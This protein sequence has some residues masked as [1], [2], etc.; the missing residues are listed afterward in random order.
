MNNRINYPKRNFF[1]FRFIKGGVAGLYLLCLICTKVDAGAQ[2]V[3][4]KFKHIT[5]EQ[6]LSSNR[7]LCILR[8]SRDF[9]WVGTDMGLNKFDG[10]D[11]T[12]YLHDSHKKGT[13][14]G[15]SI[16][17][18]TED[19]HRNL[20]FGTSEGL[21]L[22][23]RAADSFITFKNNPA[24]P[25]SISSNFIISIYLDKKQNFWILAGGNCL[26]L[27]VPSKRH[28]IRYQF[29]PFEDSYFFS[30]PSIVEDSKGNIW[31]TSFGDSLF[32][33]EQKSQKFISYDLALNSSQKTFNS[34]Y[35]D[36]QEKLWITSRGGGLHS[37]EP[38]TKK[39]EHFQIKADGT[40]TNKS[41]LHWII[42]ED[43]KHLLIA[44]DQGGINRF[45]LE[46]KRFEYIEYKEDD[47]QG[48][49]N[50]AIWTLYK[51]K[52]GILWVGTANGGINYHNPKE[53]NFNL[54]KKG[55][56]AANPNSNLIGGFL[57]D[58]KGKIW[59]ATDDNGINVFDPQ[60]KTFSFYQHN[61]ANPYSVSGNII[62]SIEEDRQGNIWV[63]TW[64]AGLNRFNRTTKTFDRFLPDKKQPSS[65]SGSRIWYLKRDY[66]GLIWSSVMDIGIDILDPKKGVV[67][68]YR[69][70]SDN[71]FG[72]GSDVIWLFV[73]DRQRNMWVCTWKGLYRYDSAHDG[74]IGYK[75]FPD[76]DIR[77]FLQDSK[78]N[79]WAGSA[80]KGIFKFSLDGKVLNQYDMNHGLP[81][82]QVNAM[83]E[84]NNG[85]IWITTNLGLSLYDPDKDKFHNYSIHDGLQGNQ[86]FMQSF[87]KTRAGDIYFGGF[88]GFNSFNPV[89]LKKNN[90]HTPVYIT[91]FQV[92][93]KRVIPGMPD[94][95]LQNQI[96]ETKEIKL[97]WKQSVFSF[98][99]TAINYT[100]SAK[101]QYAYK[102]DGF[103]KEWNYVGDKRT[104]T[105]TNLDP[106]EYVFRVKASNNNGVWNEKGT[107]I[108]IIITPP[109][110]ATWWFRIM[111]ALIII[112]GAVSFYR[113]RIN[114]VE[115]ARKDLE[116]QVLE[117]TREERAARN[118]A[119]EANKAKSIFLATMS[120][121]IRTPMNGVI[122]TASLLADTPLSEEQRRYT[123]IIRSSGESLLTVINDILDFSKIE[124]GKIDLEEVPFN[125]RSSMEEVLDLFATKAA[126][127]GIDLIYQ[128][129]SAIPQ[130]IVGDCVRLK[131]VMINLIGNAIKFT[132]KGEVFLD[133]K[134]LQKKEHDLQLSFHIHDTGIGIPKEKIERLFQAF[135]Q[136]DSSTTRKYGGTGLGLAISKRLVEL[137]GGNISVESELGK[138]T[139]F[140]I[141]VKV[142][143][144][145]NII[146]NTIMDDL[147]GL[148]GKKVLIVDDNETSRFVL[149]KQLEDW[150]FNVLAA[151]S[152]KQALKLL[153]TENTIDLVISDMQMPDMD[154][155]VL[156]KEIAKQSAVLPV[157][158]LSSIGG[159][160]DWETTRE[161]TYRLAKPV[162]QQQLCKAI[163][164]ALKDFVQTNAEPELQK[165]NAGFAEQY[166][167]EI[168][169][170]EDNPVNQ[171]V[172]IMILKKLGYKA[173]VVLNGEQALEA[174]R[175]KPYQLILMDVQ[176]PE[177]DGLEATRRIRQLFDEQPIIV[178]LTANAMQEDREECL[179]AGMNEYISKPIEIDKLTVVLKNSAAS[180]IR[181]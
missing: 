140:S 13:I 67:K 106:G 82:N 178:A 24:D 74:F 138:G 135:M 177:M 49:N 39:I 114:A 92:F 169:V 90:F 20:W 104:A 21:N 55:N 147:D 76:N 100:F 168:L 118:E 30:A 154:G 64:D 160:N 96:S 161:F 83:I 41:L 125:L 38:R 84:D 174:L 133:I 27:W 23:D 61:P 59:I 3:N 17:C 40:G 4:M 56:T 120:H 171:M 129:D 105:Y 36:K 146:V 163:A 69:V 5:V 6:G 87:L 10:Y 46:T 150:K 16:R 170:A 44:I 70:D 103:D 172:I 73:E 165:I 153:R 28:F 162:K 35:I 112:V 88:N 127:S 53:Y 155:V 19:A 58:S 22:Y 113:I 66:K 71:P 145:K 62:R 79:L 108:K 152:G 181:L 137:M 139:T 132:V 124:A 86:F 85:K 111:T 158:M 32:C 68:R 98:G 148:E 63:G 15:N 134:L 110:W 42:E 9:L 121:E 94:A 57:E 7:V 119:E 123:E 78:G 130:E 52:E 50:N 77:S 131:Q 141:S 102:L 107:S 143:S 179:R 99:F 167:L 149:R 29:K 47:K 31:T 11:V 159:E 116:Q 72:L 101:N 93:N 151:E 175:N 51:D 156:F 25:N 136:V 97:S 126:K 14:S 18:I 117:R 60:T 1:F 91:D 176:M 80:S 26:N 180:L 115:A 109:F 45:N 157:I 48:L 2:Q 33:L 122:G 75:N 43:E 95:L 8:D 65:I 12:R 166:P 34:L 144:G 173:D 54:Y 81:N 142:R 128:L 89:Q 37:F 164:M